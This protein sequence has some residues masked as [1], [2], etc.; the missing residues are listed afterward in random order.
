MKRCRLLPLLA[1]LALPAGAHAATCPVAPDPSALPGADALRSMNAVI[2]KGARPTGGVRQQRYVRWLRDQ[3]RAVPGIELEERRYEINRWNAKRTTLVLRAGGRSVALPV[4]APVPYARA[5]GQ[6]GVTAPLAFVPDGEAISAGNAAGKIVV[7]NAPA[8]S[9]G[10]AAFLLPVIS[11]SV[12]DPEG[13]ID[14]AGTFYG[15]FMNY[16][17]RVA[18]LRDAASAGARGVVFVKER[19]R[20]QLRGHYEPYEGSAWKVPAVFLGADEGKRL[21]DAVAAGGATARL[22]LRARFRK[23]TTPTILATLPGASPQRIVIDSHTDG[24]NA[25][26]DN[27]PVAMVAMARYFAA[28]PAACRPRTLEFS[29]TTAHFYQRLTDPSQRHG[30][31]GALAAELDADYDKGTVSAVVVLEHL[32]ARDYEGVPRSGGRPGVRLAQNGL[33]SIQFVAVTPSPALVSAVGDVV[34][35]YDMQRTIMLQGADLPAASV[36]SHCSFG[37][38]GTPYNQRL[39]PTVAAI[40]APQTLYDPAFGLEGIDFEVMRSE[41]LG[42]TELINRMGTMSQ[43]DVAGE[44]TV[45][46]QR[47]AAG[48][49]GCPS[50]N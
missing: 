4:A 25:V 12:Y 9:V 42:F 29:F 35:A 23:V 45:E 11:W 8:G 22:T 17:A 6:R 18:D 31:A 30:G 1:V 27:G 41:V 20:S 2:A 46:R 14:P 43:Q 7:R 50:E 26:E 44:V 38:Q 24:T 28:L 48:A 3:M 16:N 36:P 5:T 33:R 37:G 32:G 13:T 34:R 10:M 15:D 39:L 47:R 49:A 40:A 21:T 19:P